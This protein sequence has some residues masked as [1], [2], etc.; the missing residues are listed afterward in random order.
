MSNVTT[1]SVPG[2][3]PTV[4]AVMWLVVGFALMASGVVARIPQVMPAW[5]ASSVVGWI[6][7]YRRSP[8]VRA[9]ADAIDLRVLVIAHAIR[10]PIGVL[11]IYEMT[12]GRLAPMFAERAGYGDIVIG[13]LA[14]VV[15]LAVPAHK[16]IVA[17]FSWIGLADIF[18]VLGTGMY[19]LLIVKDP[20]LVG[21]ISHLPYPLIPALVVPLV[22]L[23]HCLAI[24]RVRR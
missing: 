3:S 20:L 6:V 22:I 4:A 15:T 19:L 16:R 13:M 9:W 8:A 23:A 2:F 17:V 10:L 24:A 11:F 1:R 14:V 7:G 18:V 5:I 12:R 21:P